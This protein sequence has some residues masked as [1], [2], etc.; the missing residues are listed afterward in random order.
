MWNNTDREKR[1]IASLQSANQQLQREIVERRRIENVLREMM[2]RYQKTSLQLRS[3]INA[4]PDIV[5]FKDASGKW[6]EANEAMLK[7]FD[8]E[9]VDYQ[10]K[11]DAELGEINSFYR[12]AFLACQHSDLDAWEQGSL[13]RGEVAIAKQNGTLKIYDV[14]KVPLFYPDGSR[15]RLVVLGRDIT[16]RKQVEKTNFLLASIVQSSD[17]AII[18]HTLGGIIYSWN[19]GAEK[20][21]GYNAAEVKGKFISLLTIPDRPNEMRQILENLASGASIE[22]YETVHLR[23]D[24]KLIDVSLTMSP[25]KDDFGEVIAVSTIARD[26]SDRKQIEIALEQLRYQNQ[27]ILESAGEG[28]CGL[29]LDGKITFANPAAARMTGYSVK[30]LVNRNWGLVSDLGTAKKGT[31]REIYQGDI[32]E[33]N[34]ENTDRYCQISATLAEG[35][36]CYIDREVFWRKDGSNFPVEYVSTP[37][38]KHGEIIG[39]VVTFKDITERLAIERMKDEF[40]SVVSHELRTPLASLHGA[41]GLLKSGLLNQEKQRGERLLN[42]AVANADRLVHLISDILDLER[43]NSNQVFMVKKPCDVAKLMVQAA[44]EIQPIAEKAGVTLWVMPLEVQVWGCA[45]RL[46]QTL[47]NLLSNAIKFSPPGSNIRLS[48]NCQL[49]PPNQDQ[50]NSLSNNNSQEVLIVVQDEGRGIPADKLETIF[51]RFQQVDASDSR[52]KGGTGL[53]LAIC[54]SIVQQHNGRIWAESTLGK[55]SSF[56]VALPIFKESPLLKTESG[57][58]KK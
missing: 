28:I 43:L 52:E 1:L 32:L 15:N 14:I 40:I 20:I 18:G 45:D 42:I 53:G 56:F 36:V 11:T 46:I 34:Q 48:A 33:I 54:R 24:G 10:G 55:G 6:L 13:Y 39:A 47:T 12:E 21:Y 9:E 22:R 27:L 17:D 26:V 44:T 8:L 31:I 57:L 30:E 41:L 19:Y 49:S 37:I 4:M 7:L 2:E 3:L 5:C 51:G 29:D 50:V 38:K 16:E 58:Y 25:I 23:K 35:V